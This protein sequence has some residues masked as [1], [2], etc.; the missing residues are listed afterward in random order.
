MIRSEGIVFVVCHIHSA[1]HIITGVYQF[2]LELKALEGHEHVSKYLPAY[3]SAINGEHRHTALL[4]GGSRVR[5]NPNPKAV[6]AA[7]AEVRTDF[8]R[9]AASMRLST[10]TAMAASAC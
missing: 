2:Q 1:I 7:K 10:A 4:H 5:G 9:P 3:F 8:G 6:Y